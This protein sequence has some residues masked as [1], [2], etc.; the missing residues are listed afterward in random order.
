MPLIR[1]DL[2][3]GKPA[4]YRAALRDVV[5]ET[6]NEVVGVPDDDRHEVIAEH[7]PENLNIAP[8]FFGVE[9]SADAVLIQITLNEGRD[10]Q[11]KQAFYKA[12]VANLQRKIGL[13][14]ADVTV[15]LLEVKPEN[16]SFGDGVAQ[17]V[18]AK[19]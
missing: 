2:R 6:L 16:W 1:I 11:Q 10:V 9:R 3:E 4:D 19:P 13:R 12:L 5:F 18:E 14:P 15:N 7:S 8:V 17:Y